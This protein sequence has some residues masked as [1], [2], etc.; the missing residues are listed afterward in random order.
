MRKN[1][2][3][4]AMAGAAGAA[5]LMAG[6]ANAV[7]S[8]ARQ[9]GMACAACHTVFPELTSF[10]RQFKLNGY[11]L[12]GMQ[13]VQQGAS[14]SSGGLKI[15]EIPPLSAMLQVGATH[16]SKDVPGEQNNYVE[17][18][19]QLSFFFA[20]EI[21]PHIGSFIQI[22]YAQ[23]DDKFGWDNTDIR[24]ANH[25][26]V[27]GKDTI[28]GVTLNNAPTVEDPWNSTPVWGFPFSGPPDNAPAP[29]AGTLLGSGAL[30]QDVAGLG[31]YALWGGH[32]Y[33]NL[34]LYRSAHLGQD[35]PTQTG[36][37]NTLDNFAPYWR[38]AWQQNFGQNYLEVG[39]YGM[40]AKLYPSGISGN[41]DDYTDTA[42]DAQYEMPIGD[43]LLSVHA[44]YIHEKQHLS[45]T[46]PGNDTKLNDFKLNGI[47]H[48]G[49]RAEA[50]L[51]YFN[52]S[53]DANAALY[54]TT[55]GKP[56]SNGWTAQASYLPWQNTKLTL[57][58]TAYTKF[59]GASSNYDGAGRSASDNNTLFLQG[60]FMW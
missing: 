60:W 55:N 56:N 40:Y 53:G 48:W 12:T 37:T 5:L 31:G 30:A 24:Y 8:F 3:Q 1:V 23:P 13:Q 59:D 17:F 6:N 20:G 2:I 36:S 43:H 57:Q 18:P 22:T 4:L 41:T 58:Y 10:G 47:Y 35:A 26:T 44:N 21:T 51:G 39:T 42:V 7:P 49:N 14:S 34:T 45:V 9:T 52:I 15:N 50:A 29:T 46:N 33:G 27:A 54:G 11:T 38:L 25:A 28:Y 16:I 19:Q 32:L